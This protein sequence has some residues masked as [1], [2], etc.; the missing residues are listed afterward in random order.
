[1]AASSARLANRILVGLG[2]GLAAGLL[3][4]WAGQLSPGVLAGAKRI[5]SGVLDPFGQVFLRLLFFT[6]L[7]LVFASLAGGVVNLGGGRRLGP[8]A[9]RTFGLFGLNMTIG[10][11]LGL[12]VMNTVAP[13]ERLAPETRDALREA[14]AGDAARHVATSEAREPFSLMTAV[15]MFM[16]RNLAGAVTGFTRGG[17]GEVLPL[18][19]FALLVGLAGAGLAEERRKRLGEALETVTALMT[20]IVGYA[21]RLAPYAVPAMIY[22]VVVRTGVEFIAALAWFVASV[23]GVLALHLFGTMSI[24][25]RLFSRRWRPL[26]FFRVARPVLVTAFSTSSSS[27]TMA[28]SMTLA[29]DEL[30]ISPGTAGFVI[31]LGATMNMSG[32]ALFE[33]CVVLFVAQV[34]GVELSLP[35]QLT[36]LVLSV[37]SAV[38]VAGIPGG[39]L[40]L[41]A[42]LCATFG[43]PPD[44]I[45]IVLGV[46]RLL[47]M[48]RT[49]VN[50]GADLVTC[51]VVDEYTGQAE[52]ER[53]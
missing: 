42:G 52:A 38:A 32:T 17:L 5:A 22:S 11:A 1:M 53:Q 30:K 18:I 14:Y 45:A 49:A 28:A 13:G 23:L 41:I 40:P 44:G 16:P 29:R 9:A 25:L 20:T 35:A 15:D 33:G 34:F 19:L 31:P 10:V 50:V 4:L 21:L 39:S 43:V 46:D 47:D 8:L 26:A 36:L 24:I 6:V 2:V 27:A 7:P 51:V 48:A 12:L 3:T 37:L